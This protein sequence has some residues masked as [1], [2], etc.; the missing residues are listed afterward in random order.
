MVEQVIDQDF[1]FKGKLVVIADVP[2]GIC[3]QCGAKVVKAE[4]GRQI[5]ELA[6][7]TKRGAQIRTIKVPVIQ[8]TAKVA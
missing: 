7:D 1:W 2:T 4:V 3:P 8:F 5:A 6:A